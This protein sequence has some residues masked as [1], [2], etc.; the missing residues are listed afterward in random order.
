MQKVS[1]AHMVWF[2]VQAMRIMVV[3]VGNQVGRVVRNDAY[4]G[5]YAEWN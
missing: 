5:I 2:L 1:T 4:Y 3:P